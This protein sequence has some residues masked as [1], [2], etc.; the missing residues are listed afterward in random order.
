MGLLGWGW[1]YQGRRLSKR[2][3]KGAP[4]V[5]LLRVSRAGVMASRSWRWGLT[6]SVVTL[7]GWRRRGHKG[8]A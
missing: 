7:R 5:R 4:R 3:G 8:T 2:G 6:V 1:E